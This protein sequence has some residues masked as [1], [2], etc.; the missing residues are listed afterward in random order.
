MYRFT[1]SVLVIWEPHAA[2]I[3]ELLQAAEASDL[4]PPRPLLSVELSVFAGLWRP[5]RSPNSAQVLYISSRMTILTVQSPTQS[6][7]RMLE[8]DGDTREISHFSLASG[9]TVS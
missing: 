3:Q 8:S 9:A 5:H 4:A 6:D 2:I 1:R 7:D